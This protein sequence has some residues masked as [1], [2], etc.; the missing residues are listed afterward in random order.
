MNSVYYRIEKMV[1]GCLV[2]TFLKTH[3]AAP[4]PFNSKEISKEEYDLEMLK[5]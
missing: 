2:V 5:T 1:D 4:K 3:E